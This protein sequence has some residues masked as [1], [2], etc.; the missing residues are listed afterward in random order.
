MFPGSLDEGSRPTMLREPCPLF[1]SGIG[2]LKVRVRVLNGMEAGIYSGRDLRE[3]TYLVRSEAQTTCKQPG[4]ERLLG[5]E[6]EP[7]RMPWRR[8]APRTTQQD[9]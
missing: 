3:K 9:T 4:E 8:Q 6:Q 2:T 5:L 1:L 7:G